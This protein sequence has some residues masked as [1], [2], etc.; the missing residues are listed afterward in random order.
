MTG[1]DERSP[2][3]AKNYSNPKSSGLMQNNSVCV[4]PNLY[5][6]SYTYERMALFCLILSGALKQEKVQ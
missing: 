6:S 4:S 2:K 5:G 3:L 1:D